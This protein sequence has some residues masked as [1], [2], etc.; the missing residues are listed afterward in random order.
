MLLIQLV[1]FENFRCQIVR[2]GDL[3]ST[4]CCLLSTDF[5][6]S[7]ALNDT[8]SDGV[9]NCQPRVALRTKL[10]QSYNLMSDYVSLIKSTFQLIK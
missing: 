2:N 10:S 5:L 7:R 3:V 8:P 9:S 6:K 4:N 1:L